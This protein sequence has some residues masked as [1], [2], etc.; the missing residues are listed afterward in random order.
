ML[1]LFG[2]MRASNPTGPTPK[3][4][5]ERPIHALMEWHLERKLVSPMLRAS[6]LP[7]DQDLPHGAARPHVPLCQD[8]CATPNVHGTNC[9]LLWSTSRMNTTSRVSTFCCNPA[10]PLQMHK[11]DKPK[12][13]TNA[14]Q[15]TNN[16]HHHPH[17]ARQRTCLPFLHHDKAELVATHQLGGTRCGTITTNWPPP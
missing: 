15:T 17:P 4:F 3:Q 6:E 8:L 1:L 16:Q 14:G 7:R 12:L 13:C 2:K 9:S 10:R 11:A 5:K